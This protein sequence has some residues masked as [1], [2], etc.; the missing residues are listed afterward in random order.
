MM[1]S[2]PPFVHFRAR[3]NAKPVEIETRKEKEKKENRKRKTKKSETGA[4]NP[5]PQQPT[6]APRNNPQLTNATITPQPSKQHNI[7]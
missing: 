1:A 5:K 7:K 2:K 6:Q 4:T 3:T